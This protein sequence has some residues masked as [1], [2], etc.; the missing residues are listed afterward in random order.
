MALLVAQAELE[1]YVFK[2]AAS[3]T[4]AE[5][6]ILATIGAAVSARIEDLCGPVLNASFTEKYDGPGAPWLFLRRYPVVQVTSVAEDGV[7]L[8]AGTHYLLYPERGALL[9]VSS[10]APVAWTSSPQGIQITYTAGRAADVAS[11][12]DAI[13]QAVFM[14]A[15][16]IYHAQP[17]NITGQITEAQIQRNLGRIPEPVRALLEPYIQVSL[18]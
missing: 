12:P 2:D 13:K 1:S 15:Y 14:W 11:V 4:A 3:R 8:A 10:G 6:A 17:D 5:K 18:A 9:R 16:E 7:V